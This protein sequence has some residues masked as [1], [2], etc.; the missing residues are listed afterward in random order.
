MALKEPASMD[1]L[2]YFT[3]RNLGD[4]GKIKAWAYR[5]NCPKCNKALM[6]KPKGEKGKV[7]IRANEYT[8]PS[9]NYTVQKEEYEDTLTFEGNYTCPHCQFEGEAQVP[10]I[11]KKKKI[12]DEESQKKTAVESVSFPCKSCGKIIDVTKKM[13]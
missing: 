8:C 5:N 7:K 12:F 3:N 9:C 11:R 4:K 10:F 6:G 2:V 13:K 1:D